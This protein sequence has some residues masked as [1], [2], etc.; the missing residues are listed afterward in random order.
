MAKIDDLLTHVTDHD[1]RARLEA[2]VAEL[3][4]R[5]KFG[6]VFEQHLPETALLPSSRVRL[7]NAVMLRRKPQS[8]AVFVVMAIKGATASIAD[9]EGKTR[10]VPTTDL[11]VV[12]PFGEPVYP[13]LKCTD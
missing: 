10:A 6:L 4:Q 5:K 12:K 8:T 2:A 7:G 3:R 9:A 11:L 13:V 1:L